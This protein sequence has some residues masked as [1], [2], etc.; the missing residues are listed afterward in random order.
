ME[1]ND[2]VLV[3]SVFSE[4]VLY[5]NNT[6]YATIHDDYELSEHLA[7][8]SPMYFVVRKVFRDY[9]CYTHNGDGWPENLAELVNYKKEDDND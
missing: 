7:D 4:D 8:L 9:L 6:L 1:F 3:S 5:V 2:V